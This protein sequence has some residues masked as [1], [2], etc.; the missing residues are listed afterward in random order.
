MLARTVED[1]ARV[2]GALGGLE[3]ERSVDPADPQTNLGSHQ[4]FP[5]D[6]IYT[7]DR[8]GLSGVRLGV[9]RTFA[10]NADAEVAAL[11]DAALRDLTASGARKL[12]FP[13]QIS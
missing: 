1:A 6:W 9:L 11:F 13:V 12:P 5:D 8:D 10:D 3:N 2:F 4:P 7:L